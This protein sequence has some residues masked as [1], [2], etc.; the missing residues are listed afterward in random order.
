MTKKPKK[1]Q[2]QRFFGF[3]HF[4]Q[5]GNF[6]SEIVN[7]SNK[8]PFWRGTP[9]NFPL[10]GMGGV[11]FFEGSKN[12]PKMGRFSYPQ[13]WRFSAFTFRRKNMVL[14]PKWVT[15]FWTKKWSKNGS[16][17]WRPQK[18]RIYNFLN[19]STKNHPKIHFFRVFFGFD[20]KRVFFR[21]PCFSHHNSCH[22]CSKPLKNRHFGAPRFLAIFR[23][24]KT[25]NSEFRGWFYTIWLQKG[26]KKWVGFWPEVLK[27]AKN[28]VFDRFW[29]PFFMTVYLW[30]AKYGALDLAKSGFRTFI[31]KV[32]FGPPK[33]HFLPFW[34]T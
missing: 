26:V 4:G 2:K 14:T 33:N 25:T 28:T 31:L 10:I 27:K 7:M 13:K 3:G 18:V 11:V 21:K 30:N 19:R 8:N 24:S 6:G 5:N 34:Y 17:F 23:I 22:N 20:Q 12:G 16:R 1:H 9:E 15:H 32:V 29:G